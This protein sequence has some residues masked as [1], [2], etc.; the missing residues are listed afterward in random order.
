MPFYS[1]D[2]PHTCGPDP[3]VIVMDWF[4]NQRTWIHIWYISDEHNFFS[5]NIEMSGLLP[6]WLFTPPRGETL[7]PLE[8][9][10]QKDHSGEMN[11]PI[12]A[13]WFFLIQYDNVAAKRCWT[14][15]S[16]T[17][18]GIFATILSFFT[19]LFINIQ[20]HFHFPKLTFSFQY[21][22]KSQLYKTDV[23]FV[24]LGDDFRYVQDF[25]IHFWTY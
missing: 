25:V 19:V 8:G 10:A 5:Q 17:W 24:P 12:F 16:S 21:R 15:S 3:K 11:H 6:V 2:I 14:R 13:K 7:L 18:P 23:L 20:G 22:K 1:Y 4:L 9:A